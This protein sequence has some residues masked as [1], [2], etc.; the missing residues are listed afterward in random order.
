MSSKTLFLTEELYDYMRSVSLREPEI[1]VRL[2]EE[3]AQ[4]SMHMMQISP[5]QGQFLSLLVR[6]S[7][8]SKALEIG[9]YTGYSSLCVAMALPEHGS[10][11]V[12]DVSEKWTQI[13]GRY[14]NEAGVSS[15]IRLYLAPALETLDNLL[16]DGE[17]E[18]FDFV[19]IDAD[20]ENYEAYYERCLRLLRPGGLITVDNVF[21]GG[22][23]AASE[24][25]D[26]DTRAIRTLNQKIHK[27][28]RVRLSMLPIGD[29]LTLA[30]KK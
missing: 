16:A 8:A 12:C 28:P 2:R 1:L 10:L 9:A 13:A 23:V 19:F 21:W 18:T 27:D 4:D 5:E 22:S 11:T 6:L 15:K 20:K 26:S 3:T 14:W 17:V 7:G 29:G 25:E 24:I 30:L